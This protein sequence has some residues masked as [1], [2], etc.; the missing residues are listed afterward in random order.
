MKSLV[1]GLVL[2]LSSSA[3]AQYQARPNIYGGY[4]YYYQGRYQ[5]QVVPNIYGGFNYRGTPRTVPNYVPRPVP[6]IN[7][8]FGNGPVNRNYYPDKPRSGTYGPGGW[9]PNDR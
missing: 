4:N 7:K 1:L 8:G 6:E 5:G 2:L 9:K 3:S